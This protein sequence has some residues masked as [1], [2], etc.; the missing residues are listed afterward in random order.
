MQ[1]TCEVAPDAQQMRAVR[2][3]LRELLS[4]WQLDDRLANAVLDVTHELLVNAHQHGAP[5]VRLVV[6]AG[7]DAIRADVRDAS[8]V[9]ARVLPYRPGFSERGLGLRLVRQLSTQWGQ[10]TDDDGKSVWASFARRT[11]RTA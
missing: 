1:L 3:R 7:T 2:D 9:P 5:P 11:L 8:P 4:H 10:T 6:E